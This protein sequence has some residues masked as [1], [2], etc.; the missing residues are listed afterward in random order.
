[1]LD[2]LLTFDKSGTASR[3]VNLAETIM[4]EAPDLPEQWHVYS[5]DDLRSTLN[6]FGLKEA[7]ARATVEGSS[8]PATP[9]E[10]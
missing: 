10:K 3:L 1:V 7:A 9:K 6:R 5:K 8:V 2:S 4:I